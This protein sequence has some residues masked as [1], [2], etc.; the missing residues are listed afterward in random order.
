MADVHQ[1]PT[2]RNVEQEAS[3]WIARLEAEDVT[4]DDRVRFE[5]WLRANPRNSQAFE[6]VSAT[7]RRFVEAGPLADTSTGAGAGASANVSVAPNVGTAVNV[8]AG[9]P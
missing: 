1:L 4:P 6:D 3:E 5:A 9:A 7:W 8:S 2:L